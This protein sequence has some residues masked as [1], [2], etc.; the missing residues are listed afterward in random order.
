ME[1]AQVNLGTAICRRRRAE[2]D[3][4]SDMDTPG[5]YYTDTLHTIAL[6]TRETDFGSIVEPI[7]ITLKTYKQFHVHGHPINGYGFPPQ[8]MLSSMITAPRVPEVEKP[9]TSN[10]VQN[11]VKEEVKEEQIK[12]T[13]P[14]PK[15]KWIKEYLGEFHVVLL[16]CKLSAS[17]LLMMVYL[18][19]D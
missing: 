1:S 15:K 4:F 3:L 6:N 18:V 14:P 10:Y 2:P 13:R 11:H 5:E 19:F 16:L 7:P 9:S 8:Q 17:G 12:I